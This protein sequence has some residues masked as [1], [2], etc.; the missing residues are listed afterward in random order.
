MD[1]I[2]NF[3]YKIAKR[4]WTGFFLVVAMLLFSFKRE[5]WNLLVLFFCYSQPSTILIC[6]SSMT[7]ILSW[8]WGKTNKSKTTR[9][10]Q[11]KQNKKCLT[12]P[13]SPGLPHMKHQWLVIYVN[14]FVWIFVSHYICIG[15]WILEE[16]SSKMEKF[17]PT[18]LPLGLKHKF[19]VR[20]KKLCSSSRYTKKQFKSS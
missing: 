5:Q 11:T 6:L 1:D 15:Y 16:N 4:Y 10:K 18:S 8:I 20:N 9:N 19:F 13:L 2:Q 12:A 14:L 3:R 7:S 17:K